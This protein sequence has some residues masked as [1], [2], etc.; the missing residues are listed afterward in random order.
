M[1]VPLRREDRLSVRY[2]C[3][4]SEGRNLSPNFK[5]ISGSQLPGIVN[6]GSE[7][8]DRGACWQGT[9]KPVCKEASNGY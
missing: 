1:G 8:E 3:L 2:C 9:L 7:G 4:N 6:A 5:K